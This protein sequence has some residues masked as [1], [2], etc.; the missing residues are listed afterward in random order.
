M[1]ANEVAG[2]VTVVVL[3][4][5]SGTLGEAAVASARAQTWPDVE[6]IVVDNASADESLELIESTHPSIKVI[7]NSENLGFARGMNV[8]IAA[9]S[10]EFVLPLNCDAEL[11]PLYIETLIDVLRREPTAAAAGGRVES[12]RVEVSGPLSITQTMRTRSLPVT[13]AMTCDKVNGACPLFRGAALRSVRERFGGPYDPTYD[14]YGED[15]D[16]ALT[17]G[18]LGWTYHYEPAASASHVRSYGSASKLANRRG[19]FRTSTLANR[20]RNI[21]RHAPGLWWLRSLFAFVQDTGFA[22]LRLI[23]GDVRAPV[24]VGKAWAQVARNAGDDRAKRHQLAD[25]RWLSRM[26]SST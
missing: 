14:M 23:R 4:W 25:P 8:G 7:S 10:G 22:V 15:V 6:V 20:Q 18:R 19:R 3:N 13:D 21:I 24:D 1:S 5:N 9:A 17:L 2:R 26:E 11:D 16:L 12:S